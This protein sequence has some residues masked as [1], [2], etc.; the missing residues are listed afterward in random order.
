MSH[1][2]G[3][4][5]SSPSRRLL[6]RCGHK[7]SGITA[8]VQ[9]WQHILMLHAYHHATDGDC[10]Q[11]LYAPKAG[12]VIVPSHRIVLLDVPMER[13]ACSWDERFTKRLVIA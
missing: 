9:S 3:T 10:V 6:T 11:V 7:P 13:I 1:F 4:L 5:A 8:S 2:Y 12:N